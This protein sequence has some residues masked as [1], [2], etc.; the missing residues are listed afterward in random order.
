MFDP[1]SL[2]GIVDAVQTVRLGSLV[3]CPAGFV[4]KISVSLKAMTHPIRTVRSAPAGGIADIG[5][6]RWLMMVGSK[7]CSAVHVAVGAVVVAV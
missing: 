1:A 2:A 7:S 4:E 6:C 5:I 3:L